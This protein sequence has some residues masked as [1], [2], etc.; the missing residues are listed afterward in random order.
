ME[1]SIRSGAGAASGMIAGVKSL[2]TRLVKHLRL[3]LNILDYGLGFPL[4]I[5][6]TGVLRRCRVVKRLEA[7]SAI[8]RREC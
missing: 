5:P 7:I 1:Y 2:L 4:Q 8:D 6:D 3:S